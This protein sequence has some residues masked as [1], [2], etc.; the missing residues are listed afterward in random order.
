MMFLKEMTV[1]G[2]RIYFTPN[3]AMVIPTKLWEETRD[4][5]GYV[6]SRLPVG[7]YVSSMDRVAGECGAD[8][9]KQ[10]ISKAS[11]YTNSI[12]THGGQYSVR[13]DLLVTSA[14]VNIT[15]E[16]LSAVMQ[17]REF[18]DNFQLSFELKGYRP[19][20][21]V[22]IGKPPANPSPGYVLKRKL[23]VRYQRS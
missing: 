3:C 20:R 17:L 2:I 1:A 21:K 10:L 9:R 23:L 5:K 18:S 19:A 22:L 7:Q 8:P 13:S 16:L 15:P 4:I 11:V 12:F 6:F 14:A